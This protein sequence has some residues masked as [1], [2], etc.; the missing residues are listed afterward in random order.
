MKKPASNY[1]LQVD[2]AKGIFLKYD[3][4]FLI[5]KFSLAADEQYIYLNY[6][7]TPCRISRKDGGVEEY[8]QN[9]WQECRSFG[10]VMTI[11]DLLCYHQGDTAPVLADQWCA[12]GTFVVTGVTN[13]ETFTKK[14]AAIFDGHI[15][16]LKNA[17]E[18]L[19]GALQPT[20][21]GADVTYRIPVTPFFPVL[22]QFWAGDE[23]FPPKLILLWDRNTHRFLHFET[24][25]YLQGDLLDRLKSCMEEI[26]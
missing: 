20:M 22:L 14:Y 25:F 17:C 26:V 2:I 1:D 24:T 3:Q 9:R 13:T 11:Y 7:N 15:T 10:T 12:V 19:G 4:E 16:E 5:R 21:A 8:I 18:K 6:I 23:E